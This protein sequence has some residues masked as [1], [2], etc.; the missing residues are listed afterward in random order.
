MIY[1]WIKNN[2][3]IADIMAA[4]PVSEEELHIALTPLARLVLRKQRQSSSEPKRTNAAEE[5]RSMID[6]GMSVQQVAKSRGTS[7]ES[8]YQLCRNHAIE[9]PA[10]KKGK[11]KSVAKVRACVTCGEPVPGKRKHCSKKCVDIGRATRTQQPNAKITMDDARQVR[12]LRSGGAKLREIAEQ[13]GL[14]IGGVNSIVA[15]R[16]WR[17]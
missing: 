7:R 11:P 14:S 6:S 9:I 17:E 12:K 13:F 2:T 3:G 1:E 5:V 15:G 4:I 10:A 16:T 8:V